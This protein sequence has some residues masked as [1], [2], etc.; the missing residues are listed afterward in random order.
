MRIQAF[1]SFIQFLKR[2][3][4][5]HGLYV[6][7]FV[8]QEKEMILFNEKMIESNAINDQISKYHSYFIKLI[9]V[10]YLCVAGATCAGGHL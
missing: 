4:K 8:E 3:L 10:I 2:V 5:S 1:T 9:V 7:E 6:A